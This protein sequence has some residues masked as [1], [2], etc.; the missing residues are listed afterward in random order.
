M[1]QTEDFVTK[2]MFSPV[3]VN[4]TVE[5]IDVM[6]LMEPLAVQDGKN[7]LE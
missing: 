7:A 1:Q 3:L 2:F 4:Y 5:M 6:D